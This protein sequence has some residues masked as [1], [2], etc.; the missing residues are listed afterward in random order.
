MK[1]LHVWIMIGVLAAFG[2]RA[3][4]DYHFFTDA[5]GRTI[6]A[7]I[8]ACE[9]A[10]N[11]V[12]LEREDNKQ[13][14][15]VPIDMFTDDDQ[16]YIKDWIDSNAFLSTRILEVKCAARQVKKWSENESA[17]V[18]YSSGNTVDDFV[19]NVIKYEQS[20][21][22]FT[23]KNREAVPIKGLELRY[24]IYYEQSYMTKAKKPKMGLKVLCGSI[25]IPDIPGNG[26]ITLSTEPVTT[27]EDDINPFP[28][29]GG[30]QRLPG[31]GKLIGIRAELAVKGRD[32]GASREIIVPALLSSKKYPWT[33]ESVPNN[34]PNSFTW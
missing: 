2:I 33:D 28:Q 12:T 9:L 21:Y 14:V 10:K 27:F 7:K 19:H 23:F 18:T 26:E 3:D 29:R 34:R 24:C 17:S 13:R 8:T 32:K 25:D 5:Q 31:K 20:A 16:R 22:V 15:T 1:R 6:S 4:E 30:D 11:K